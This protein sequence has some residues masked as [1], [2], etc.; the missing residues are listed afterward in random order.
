MLDRQSLGLL[1]FPC[2]NWRGFDS[3]FSSSQRA[4]KGDTLKLIRSL[5]SFLS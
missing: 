2:Q 1:F 4:N 5:E 3:W